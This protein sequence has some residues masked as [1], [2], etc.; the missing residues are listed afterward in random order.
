[1]SVRERLDAIAS[2]R[3][4]VLDGAMGSMIQ[5]LKLG[6]ADF[7]GERFAGHAMP[8]SGCNDLLCLTRPQAISTIHEAYLAAG[9][10]IIETCSFNATAVSL[11]DYGLADLAYEVSRAAASLARQAADAYSTADKPR[12]VAGSMGPT[13][14]SASLPSDMSDPAKRAIYWDELEAAYYDHARG[15][16]DG[17]AD[18]LLLETIFDTLNAKAALFAIGRLT[19][20][21]N[22]DIPVM[23]SATVSGDSGR[24]LCGQTLE[25]FCA[26]VRHSA[27]WSIG[28]NCSFGAEKLLPH[29]RTL[30]S[31][32]SCKIS[33]HPNAGL[34]NQQGG[35]DESP[36]TMAA[37]IERYL[38]DGLLN[39]V[40]GCCGSTPA[41]IA[42][43]AAKAALY[44]PRPLP[45]RAPVS[46]WAGISA[47]GERIDITG[48]GED[49]YEDAADSARDLID[50]GAEIV[51]IGVDDAMPDA[52]KAMGQFLN[53]LLFDP[54]IAKAPFMINSS[55][56]SVLETGLKHMPGKCLV[57]AISLKDGQEEF[58]RRASLVRRYGASAV[59]TLIDEKGQA[60][61]FERKIAVAGRAYRLLTENDFPPADIVFDPGAAEGDT[62][63]WIRDNCPGVQISGVT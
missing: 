57:N 19:R 11:G 6:E 20:E 42:A 44:Q 27:P 33:A 43:I 18:I 62:G 34:P 25:A 12:F 50:D 39:I 41:H 14:K 47:I 56:W 52:E 51:N 38:Q 2:Q 61:D 5:S 59:V 17:G 13:A 26:S 10:D 45:Q 55:R 16:L 63:A 37:C 30:S 58:L 1:M 54:H 8:L 28:L 31:S 48:S 46:H 4:L 29:I 49:A 40:G 24:L 23:I 60:I 15:L 21:R 9:A 32:M 53:T 7:R 22:S 36:E 35:Y 3:V